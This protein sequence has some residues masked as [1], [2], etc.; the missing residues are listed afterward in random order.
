MP[1]RDTGYG[2]AHRPVGARCCLKESQIPTNRAIGLNPTDVPDV[3][4]APQFEMRVRESLVVLTHDASLTTAVRAVTAQDHELFIVHAEG[5]LVTHLLGGA[6]GVVVLD[7]TAVATPIAQLTQGL[8]AQFPDVVLIVAGGAYEQAAVTAQVTSG[9]VYRFLHKPASEQRIRLFIDA[10]WR[11]RGGE[12]A[13]GNTTRTLTTF[14]EPA[15][16]RRLALPLGISALVVAAVAGIG[17]WLMGHSGGTTVTA[18]PSR[19]A[20]PRPAVTPDAAGDALLNQLLARAAEALARGDFIMPVGNSAVDL[21]RQ[22]LERH[23]GDLKAQAGL[24]K[25]VDQVLSAAEQ[26]LLAQ[27]L[28]EAEHLTQAAHAIA[29]DSVRVSFLTTQISRERERATRAQARLQLQ[30][31]Q[32]DELDRQQQLIRSARTALTAGSLDEAAR[33]ITTAADAGVDRDAID[34]LTR[35]LQGARLIAKM[36]ETLA[37]AAPVAAIETAPLTPPQAAPVVAAVQP[38]AQESDIVSANTLERLKYVEPEYPLAARSQGTSGWV[39]LA[40]DVQTDGAV[41]NVVVLA[42][43]PKNIFDR[44]AVV[45]L[46]KWHYRPVE[47]DGHAVVRRARLRIRFTV[48]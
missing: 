20:A 39:D 12:H 6:A 28:E 35:D 18:P 22:A 48:K 16:P 3:E 11:R 34:T 31:Q 8:K 2:P 38:A 5:D 44:A 24:D 43:D 9:A 46:R 30:Q 10:A 40:F 33:L 17:G 23:H 32:A 15:A 25:V 36:N 14:G 42:S 21:Y 13:S 27:H 1:H 19:H 45:A 47:R 29:P 26:D 37:N 41:G 4:P 7:T